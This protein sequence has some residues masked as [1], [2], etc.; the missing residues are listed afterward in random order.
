MEKMAKPRIGIPVNHR[1]VDGA[2]VL[3]VSEPLVQA[4]SRSGGLAIIIPCSCDEDLHGTLSLM[5]G[6]V[7]PGGLD[8]APLHYG[9]EPNGQCGSMN[10]EDDRLHL[11]V[12]RYALER[13]VPVLGIC[14]GMQALNVAAGGTLHQDISRWTTVQHRQLAPKWYAT[15][16]VV[17]EPDSLVG[18]MFGQRF[19]VN[20]FHHQAVDVLGDDL[21]VSARSSDGVIEAIEATRHPY[22][23]GLQWHPELCLD[24]DKKA[25]MP[26]LKLVEA[27]GK[28]QEG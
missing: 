26:F 3:T 16:W 21:V 4:V 20:S 22:A 28:L 11:A 18:Q 13:K 6:F 24:H 1:V 15:H 8:L 7:L 23:V 12:A 27:A 14:R 25:I 2:E 9:Q 10:P 5:Q 19:L 17:G